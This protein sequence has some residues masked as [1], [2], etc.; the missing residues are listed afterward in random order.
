MLKKLLLPV[1]I[2]VS[3]CNPAPVQAANDEETALA[4]ATYFRAARA[5][6]SKNQALINDASKGDKGLSGDVVVAAADANFKEA[7]GY[8]VD[9]VD[10]K[11]DKGKLLNAMRDAAKKVMADNQELINQEGVGLKGFLPAVFA[12]QVAKEFSASQNGV[13]E[14]KLTAPKSYVR[15]RKNRPDDWEHGIIEDKFKSEGYETGKHVAETAE[16]GGKTA[17]RLILP[18]YYK[19]SCL[20]CHGE[21][22]GELD[23]TGGKK[24]GGKLGELGGAISVTLFK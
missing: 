6:I 13:A 14:I 20:K 21:P 8:A 4:L 19:E 11:S 1:L 7:A 9:S 5:V 16:K 15:N 23:I 10:G 3:L 2:V 18:E 22:K 24:E 17:F 12:G